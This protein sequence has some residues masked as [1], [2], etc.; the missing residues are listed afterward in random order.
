MYIWWG[1]DAN[2]RGPPKSVY[3]HTQILGQRQNTGYGPDFCKKITFLHADRF[4]TVCH[5]ESI[6][7][8][9]IF[10]CDQI[11]FWSFEIFGRYWL[12]HMKP[13]IWEGVWGKKKHTGGSAEILSPFLE[14]S[15]KTF[16]NLFFSEYSS[17]A[18]V[19]KQTVMKNI[20]WARR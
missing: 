18:C 10:F 8:I 13:V 15:S 19:L 9:Q 5:R 4:W 7:L 1:F 17:N 20:V 16:K 11:M 2:L 6:V 14:M 12:L 3:N